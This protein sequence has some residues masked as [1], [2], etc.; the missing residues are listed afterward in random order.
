MAFSWRFLDETGDELG[1]SGQFPDQES[2][3]EWMGQSWADLRERGVE[4][5][6]LMDDDRNERVYRMAL[7]ES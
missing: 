2:A 6:I 4:E 1:G 7:S 3:E 5:V